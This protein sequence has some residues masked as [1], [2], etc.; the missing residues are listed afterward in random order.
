MMIALAIFPANIFVTSQ[1]R[2][3]DAIFTIQED[4][5]Q[6]VEYFKD[7]GRFLEAKRLED[8]VTFDLEMIRELG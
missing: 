1:S 2:Q 3:K 5:M 4:M 8:R 6:Q 7:Q